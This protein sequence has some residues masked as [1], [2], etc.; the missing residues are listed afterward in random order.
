[1]AV[2]VNQDSVPSGR[3]IARAAFSA[4]FAA[5]SANF[6]CLLLKYFF[7]KK[8]ADNHRWQFRGRK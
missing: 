4:V 8:A 6:D 7:P 1:M 3:P 5:E 2:R